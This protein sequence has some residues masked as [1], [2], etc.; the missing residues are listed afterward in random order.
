[1]TS[2]KSF[3]CLPFP[4]VAK[5]IQ[6]VGCV[7]SDMESA[8]ITWRMIHGNCFSSVA[9]IVAC[10]AFFALSHSLSPVTTGS[11]IVTGI[12]ISAA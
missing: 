3:S 5:V 4:C 2:F 6:L 7:S 10:E 9:F 1:M 8:M 12:F 11:M